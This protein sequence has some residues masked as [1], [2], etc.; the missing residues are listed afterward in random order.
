MIRRAR[1]AIMHPRSPRFAAPFLLAPLLLA[2]CQ[3]LPHPFAD[4]KP[5]TSTP[6]L[7]PPDAAGIVV[8][9]VAGAPPAAATAVATAMAEALMKEDVPADTAETNSGSYHLTGTATAEPVG[10][11]TRITVTWQLAGADR[12]VV[13]TETRSATVPAAAW[14][15]GN[16]D[17]ARALVA[18]VAP[19][20]ARR[21]EGDVPVEHAGT[22]ARLRITPVTGASGDGGPALSRAMTAA[23]QRAGVALQEKPGDKPSYLLAGK[24]AI[25]AASAG[26]QQVKIAWVLSRPDGK[27]IG[28]VSQENAVPAGS[29]NGKWGDTAYDVATAAVGGIVQLL[30]QVQATGS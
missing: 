18:N 3:P 16:P 10:K 19:T 7:T 28:R 14:R 15:E 17:M 21:V 26:H 29:L 24:V 6:V 5:G 1:A 8:P 20:L 27:E 13:A 9:P 30:Q 12:R 4:Q 25:G 2:A 11:R 23:L 22:T